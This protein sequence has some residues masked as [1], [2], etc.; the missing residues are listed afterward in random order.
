M[1]ETGNSTP[2]FS[3]RIGYHRIL[4]HLIN[5]SGMLSRWP[6]KTTKL[7]PIEKNSP[8]NN[9]LKEKNS[10]RN[11]KITPLSENEKPSNSP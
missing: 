2:T 6:K 4:L 3:K 8:K 11:T 9:D 1:G 7:N 10:K 5:F